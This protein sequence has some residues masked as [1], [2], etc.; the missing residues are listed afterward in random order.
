MAYKQCY[1][2]TS[3]DELESSCSIYGGTFS[4]HIHE[5]LSELAND[6]L[7]KNDVEAIDFSSL[8][9]IAA[10]SPPSSWKQS[11]RRF[12]NAN[13]VEKFKAILSFI[14]NRRLPWELRVAQRRFT[15]ITTFQVEVV[16]FYELDHVNKRIIFRLFD[17]LPGQET[18]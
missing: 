15:V 3:K 17:G 14:K 9:E 2:R 13:L 4:S 7:C 16:V 1:E 11:W 10:T 8:V 5:W 18:K 6:E 12:L